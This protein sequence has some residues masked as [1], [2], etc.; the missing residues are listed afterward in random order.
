MALED[1][2]QGFEGLS[3]EEPGVYAFDV[4]VEEFRSSMAE[5][6]KISAFRALDLQSSG[7]AT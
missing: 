5:G 6:L 7:L 1:G 3:I 2:V 4:M